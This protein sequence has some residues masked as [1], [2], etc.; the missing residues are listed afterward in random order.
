M[1]QKAEKS[2]STTWAT[3]GCIPYELLY[4]KIEQKWAR[5]K[6][7]FHAT[8]N[9]TYSSSAMSLTKTSQNLV[10]TPPN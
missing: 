7:T 9:L 6:A 3:E 10:Y 8:N 4:P 1:F 2:L 5:F